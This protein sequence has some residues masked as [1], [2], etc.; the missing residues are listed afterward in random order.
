MGRLFLSFLLCFSLANI[1]IADST[2]D[3]SLGYKLGAGDM[4]SIHVYDEEDL[5][6]ELRIG[7]SGEISYPLLGDVA[8]FGLSLIHI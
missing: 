1:S 2:I 8:V 5:S 7:L 4:I 3:S 6:L